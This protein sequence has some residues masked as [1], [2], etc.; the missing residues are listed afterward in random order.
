MDRG[1]TRR[2]IDAIHSGVLTQAPVARDAVFGLDAVLEVPG[3]D[4]RLLSP[5]RAWQNPAAWEQAARCLA[6]KFRDNFSAYALE[7]GADVLA[8]GPVA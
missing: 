5:Q 3:V 6:G 1:A 7:A 8:A 2:I 4:S